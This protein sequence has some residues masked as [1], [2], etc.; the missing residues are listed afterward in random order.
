[1]MPTILDFTCEIEEDED[2]EIAEI[3]EDTENEDVVEFENVCFSFFV[4]FSLYRKLPSP[5]PRTCLFWEIFSKGFN[6]VFGKKKVF[7]SKFFF[8]F[9]KK[10]NFV[11]EKKSFF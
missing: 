10:N 11:G 4:F 5:F 3:L 8:V 2:D 7:S 6:I 1:M 9:A